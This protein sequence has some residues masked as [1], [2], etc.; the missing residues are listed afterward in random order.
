VGKA[1]IIPT[2]RGVQMANPVIPIDVLGAL[3]ADPEAHVVGRFKGM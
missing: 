3:V 2:E 1:R